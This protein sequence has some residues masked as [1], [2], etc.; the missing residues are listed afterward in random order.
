MDKPID[1]RRAQVKWIVNDE[2]GG[3]SFDGAQL[4]VLM[5]IRDQLESI[6]NKL[7]CYRI[8]RGLDALHEIALDIRRKLRA[9]RKSAKESKD[10]ATQDHALGK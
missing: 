7:N 5:D 4:A 3:C 2:D 6:N 1:R 8:P 10:N 9:S